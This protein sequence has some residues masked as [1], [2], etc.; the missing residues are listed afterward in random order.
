MNRLCQELLSD[1]WLMSMMVICAKVTVMLILAWLVTRSLRHSS[2][3]TRQ[4]VWLLAAVCAL[5]IPA[6]GIV[7]PQIDVP[8]IPVMSDIANASPPANSERDSRLANHDDTDQAMSASAAGEK[9]S[10]MPSVHFVLA[11]IWLVGAVAYLSPLLIGLLAVRRERNRA[12]A[13]SDPVWLKMV[14]RAAREFG[15]NRPVAMYLSD[16]R[17]VPV[18]LGYFRP[19]ILLPQQ[20]ADWSRHQ[21]EMAVLHEMAHIQRHDW[22]A[23]LL[24]HVVCAVYWFNPLVWVASREL[25]F[26]SERASDDLVLLAGSDSIDYAEVLFQFASINRDAWPV[27]AATVPMAQSSTL[28][29]RLTMILDGNTTRRFLSRRVAVIGAAVAVLI[30]LPLSSLT[31]VIAASL[32]DATGIGLNALGEVNVQAIGSNRKANEGDTGRSRKNKDAAIGKRDNKNNKD[33]GNDQQGNNSDDRDADNGQ[34]GNND[35][36]DADNDQHGNND[37]KDTD[38]SKADK[39]D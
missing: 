7:L 4:L 31:P 30:S 13:V 1:P 26:E 15:V 5:A 21:V 20:A 19:C 25:R 34:H 11:A 28:E 38:N 24:M 32:G 16:S 2:A 6:L 39:D 33:A 10:P 29:K 8:I 35:D 3:A 27:A 18:M 12:Y 36:K 14:E 23:M 22:L 9:V 37:D 17:S